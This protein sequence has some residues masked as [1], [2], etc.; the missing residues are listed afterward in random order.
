[1]SDRETWVDLDDYPGYAV[2]SWGRIMNTVTEL[3]KAPSVNREGIASVNLIR[4][5]RQCR[6]SVARLVAGA[7]LE[8][9]PKPSFDTPINLDGDR[10][11][12]HADNL[13][14]RPLWFAR[15]YHTQLK[16]PVNPEWVGTVEL[17]QTGE[18]FEDVRECSTKYGLLEK[19]IILSALTQNVVFP[20]YYEFRLVS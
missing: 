9:P 12:N 1:M 10:L 8:A 13:M 14:W 20:T 17:V 18:I 3:V 19:E 2:S 4:D 5:N 7:F 11:N 16:S 6:R 15:Q